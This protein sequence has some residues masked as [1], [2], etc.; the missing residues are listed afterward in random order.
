MWFKAIP[1]LKI[2]L[3]KSELIPICKVDNV[4]YLAAELVCHV[5]NLLSTYPRSSFGRLF[6]SGFSVG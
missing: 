6:Q 5:G 1:S 4:E 2:N 3:E